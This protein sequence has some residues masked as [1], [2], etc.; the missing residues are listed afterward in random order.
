V[1]HLKNGSFRSVVATRMDGLLSTSSSSQWPFV[2]EA[3]QWPS[4]A[5]LVHNMYASES[6][7]HSEYLL[8]AG[9]AI[10]AIGHLFREIYVSLVRDEKTLCTESVSGSHPRT[11]EKWHGSILSDESC[12]A[13]KP[14][15]WRWSHLRCWRLGT[16]QCL[17]LSHLSSIGNASVWPTV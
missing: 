6:T 11:D 13:R 7:S 16:S 14:M 1:G 12:M 15:P 2:A 10:S 9:M 5:S 4:S 8:V 17:V 3:P